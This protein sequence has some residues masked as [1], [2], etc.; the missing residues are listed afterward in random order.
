MS[1]VLLATHYVRGQSSERLSDLDKVTQLGSNSDRLIPEP[2]LLAIMLYR[3]GLLLSGT[4]VDNLQAFF[5]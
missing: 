3:E 4:V 2:T 1:A 5:H